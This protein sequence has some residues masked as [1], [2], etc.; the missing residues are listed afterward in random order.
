MT[1]DVDNPRR[2]EFIGNGSDINFPYDYRIFEETDLNVIV[3]GVTQIVL[4]D[5]TVTGVNAQG[6]GNV[7]FV[8]APIDMSEVIIDSDVP[9]L[10][11]VDFEVGG[12]FKPDTVNF[13][14]DKL[15]VIDQ[16]TI[17][18][19][20]QRGLLY[21]EDAF[22]D[23]NDKD[24][25]LPVLPAQTNTEIPIWSKDSNNNIIATFLEESAD[26]SNLRAELASETKASPGT[27]LIGYFDEDNPGGPIGKTL[28][29]FLKEISELIKD[30]GLSTVP[31]G[32][33][34]AWTNETAPSGFLECDGIDIDVNSDSAPFFSKRLQ[35]VL[36]DR[37]GIGSETYWSFGAGAPANNM[38][39]AAASVGVISTPPDPGATGFTLNVT[40]TGSITQREVVNIIFIDA[41]L[42]TPGSFFTVYSPILDRPNIFWYSIDGAGVEPIL[43]GALITEIPVLSLDT[44]IDVQQ[45]TIALI[46]SGQFKIP[47]L[48][49]V[50]IRGFSKINSS[51]Q[52]RI[53]NLSITNGGAGYTVSDVLTI[54]DPATLFPSEVTVD[55]VAVGVITAVSIKSNGRFKQEAV[56]NQFP[57]GGTGTGANLDVA[58]EDFDPKVP[59]RLSYPY[60]P[61]TFADIPD[62]IIGPSVG[63]YRVG[64]VDDNISPTTSVGVSV[65]V[66]MMWIIRV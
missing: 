41:N 22:L 26:L 60:T 14:N 10:Q 25:I 20:K 42:I 33:V 43:A 32:G 38:D 40:T 4:A 28:D 11:T 37:W 8:I 24:N 56:D 16:Q 21:P 53:V 9:P 34:I 57:I 47:D 7:V 18:L 13:V 65:N 3:D 64:P 58:Y 36:L 2:L 1:I 6:G 54:N 27:G 17:T 52:K 39:A 51:Y 46:S 48:R 45:K 55:S 15:T 23:Q 12:K 61:S 50:F 5:Y 62:E 63:S 44:S 59:D 30:L 35:A 19:I 66:S 29:K 31:V 49:G